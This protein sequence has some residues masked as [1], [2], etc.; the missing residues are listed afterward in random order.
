MCAG[1]WWESLKERDQL[2][3]LD[4]DGKIIL[5]SIIKKY[6]GNVWT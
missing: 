2:D 4:I 6:S 5:K 1:F 3:Y